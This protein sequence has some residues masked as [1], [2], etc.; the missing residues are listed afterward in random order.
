SISR[1]VA[2]ARR[3]FSQSEAIP[4]LPPEPWPPY[5]RSSAA[6]ST[7]TRDQSAQSSSA[8]IIGM[9]VLTPSPMSGFFDQRVT[10][11][12]GSIRRNALGANGPVG[13]VPAA[14]DRHPAKERE[15]RNPPAAVVPTFR[16]A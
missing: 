12:S 10:V 5:F 3:R 4:S 7:F 1:A 16:N 13:R 9:E 2:P 14:R 6:C 15:R 8:T 11:P